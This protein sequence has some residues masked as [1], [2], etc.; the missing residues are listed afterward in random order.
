MSGLE[1]LQ[2]ITIKKQ[3]FMFRLIFGCGD[4]A[5][6]EEQHSYDSLYLESDKKLVSNRVKVTSAMIQVM[7]LLILNV[8]V[9]ISPQILWIKPLLMW[10]ITKIIGYVSMSMRCAVEPLKLFRFIFPASFMEYIYNI[11]MLKS[12]S[13]ILTQMSN[14][15]ILQYWK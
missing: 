8:L 15:K 5:V 2:L 1:Q 9:T 13:E 12:I 10:L 4:I 14:G 6:A 3:S 7:D 11:S